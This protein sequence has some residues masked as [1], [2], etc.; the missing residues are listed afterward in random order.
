MARL[1]FV[2]SVNPVSVELT[3]PDVG[4]ITVKD[5]VG[6]F[7]QFDPGRLFSRQMIEETDL[8]LCRIGRKKGEID[9][10]AVPMGSPLAG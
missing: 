8:D 9:A 3:G 10:V 6:V 2:G 5:L 1:G 4:E 7:R